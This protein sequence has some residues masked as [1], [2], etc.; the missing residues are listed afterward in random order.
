MSY[1]ALI[2]GASSGIGEAT[3]R[4]LPARR[5]HAT[6]VLVARRQDR[7]A[8]LAEELNRDDPSGH[9]H[10]HAFAADL[11][12]PEE[13]ARLTTEV[14]AR[15]GHLNLLVN[16]AGARWSKP[17][18]EGGY[19]NVAQTMAIN[20]DAQ[21]RLT[22][23]CLGL[24][25]AGAVTP[26][27]ASIVNVAS[28]AARVSRAGAGAYSASKFAFAGWSDALYGEL[29][30]EGIHVGLV[31]PGFIATEGFPAAELV[32]HPLKRHLVGT[33]EQAAAG[34]LAAGLEGKPEV[35]VPGFYWLFAAMR[36]LTPG[37]IRRLAGS[38]SFTTA[39][40]LDADAADTP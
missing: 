40:S 22:E 30:P 12:V 10:I 11:T 28:T 16:N 5:P 20:F 33:P 25:R 35:Y 38:G 37:L 17:F 21:V 18:S 32:S 4:L 26:E 3:A 15:F 39:T 31:N 14:S 2:T 13:V 34:I 29:K 6:V 27:H 19:A 1:V 9:H 24:L 8:A 7:I 23:A 36:T